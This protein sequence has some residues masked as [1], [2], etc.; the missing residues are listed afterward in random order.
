MIDSGSA[1]HEAELV[2]RPGERPAWQ[3]APTPTAAAYAPFSSLLR[4][5]TPESLDKAR[6]RVAKLDRAELIQRYRAAYAD[7]KRLIAYI[8]AGELIERGIPP[9]FWHEVLALESATL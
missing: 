8:M 9:C 5:V 7:G 1:Q 2:Y 3:E 4:M 6:Q